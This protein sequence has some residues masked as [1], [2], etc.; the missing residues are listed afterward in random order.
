M[1]RDSAFSI[2]MLVN[3]TLHENHTARDWFVSLTEDSAGTIRV[4]THLL[5]DGIFWI[6][7]QNFCNLNNGEAVA[8][9]LFSEWSTGE[10][11]K[12]F[13]CDIHA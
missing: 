6:Q 1:P 5:H 11:V 9:N 7:N 8:Q 4:T 10:K 13:N 12:T 3:V 2:D